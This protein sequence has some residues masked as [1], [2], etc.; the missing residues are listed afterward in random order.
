MDKIVKNDS[1]CY[2]ILF[3]RPL[4]REKGKYIYGLRMKYNE[5]KYKPISEKPLMK[6]I[7]EAI[8]GRCLFLDK[9]EGS[10]EGNRWI[11][12]EGNEY[13]GYTIHTRKYSYDVT[14]E[15]MMNYRCD[16]VYAPCEGEN[17]EHYWITD[18][19]EYFEQKAKMDENDHKSGKNQWSENYYRIQAQRKML[20]NI[21]FPKSEYLD[22]D[23]Q[24]L[25]KK[26]WDDIK[27]GCLK[28]IENEGYNKEKEDYL[29]RL[30]F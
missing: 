10:F 24:E 9:H 1:L 14:I 15:N 21:T 27:K 29:D 11:D 23:I 5:L 2:Q 12:K 16:L 28:L 4:L 18:P 25:I 20:S 6:Y 30:P 17:D 8:F 13:K 26:D 19:A 3:N 7:V 22:Y